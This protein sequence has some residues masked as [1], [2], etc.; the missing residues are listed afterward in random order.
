V[1]RPKGRDEALLALWER[2]LSHP[3][4]ARGDALL[5]NEAPPRSLGE[6]T[7]RLLKLHST[8]FG[9]HVDLLSHCPQCDSVAQFTSDCEQLMAH[10]PLIADDAPHR[11]ELDD[12]EIQFRLPVGADLAAAAGGDSDEHFAR[13]VLQ[14]CVLSCTR[15]G[16]GVEL[17]AVPDA[18]LDALSRRIEHLD[19]GST[20][21]FAVECP[22]CGTRWNAP[23]DV[24][25]LVW[26][27]VQVAAERLLLDID[28]L[29][30]TYGW[31]EDEVLRLSPARRAAYLQIVTS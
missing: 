24:G 11:L 7:V 1:S 3:V 23:L 31:T 5:Q 28:A 2:G 19:P 8:F 25:R 20:I 10:M 6:R 30:R 16:K 9:R 21:S 12:L 29:A 18:V 4:H 27:K 26:Q 17:S 14:R 22:Q 15:A 13:Y